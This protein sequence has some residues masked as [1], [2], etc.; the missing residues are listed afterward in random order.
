[1]D[2]V[3]IYRSPVEKSQ[4]R[5]SNDLKGGI[6]RHKV[7]NERLIVGMNV[8]GERMRTR[9]MFVPEVAADVRPLW[10]SVG[11]GSPLMR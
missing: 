8:V 6:A 10:E 5:R 2:S 7:L 4:C 9:Q 11:S 3:W 1:M